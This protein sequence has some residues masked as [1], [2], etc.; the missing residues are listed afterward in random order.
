[1]AEE[2]V[3]KKRTR[4]P[5]KAKTEKTDKRSITDEKGKKLVDYINKEF[6]AEDKKEKRAIIAVAVR[7]FR[8]VKQ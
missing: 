6:S 7:A 5:A 2:A 4:A 1:M 3:P 8:T